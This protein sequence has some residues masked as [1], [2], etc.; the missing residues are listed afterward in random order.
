MKTKNEPSSTTQRNW[1]KLLLIG[2][3]ATV[4]PGGF[5]ALGIYGIKRY[6]D[7]R[8]RKNVQTP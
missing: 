6:F 7:E 2:V 1:K 8:K 4:T 5:I 3:V